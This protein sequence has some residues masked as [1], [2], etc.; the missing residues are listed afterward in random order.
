[1]TDLVLSSQQLTV[2]SALSSGATMTDAAE[3]A[4]V[5][6]NTIANWRRNF[7]PFEHALAH[8]Q[9]DRA[10]LFREKAEALADLAIQ[11]IQAIL[12][13]PKASAG[14]R[15]KAALAILQT[16]S[17]P[18]EPKKQIV[19]EI[20]KIKLADKPQ[21]EESN[22]HN[23]AQP[24]PQAPPQTVHNSAQQPRNVGPKIGRNDICPCGSG[25]KFK[26][27]CLNKPSSAPLA[28]AA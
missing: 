13:D 21:P 26:R 25:Q 3:E 18:P 28:A 14:V 2:I 9:Y 24:T 16:A 7:L 12:V 5:H 8:A 15:L 19:M 27:C 22:L 1:M 20:E 10:L 4:G 17:T 6:R 11:T 23:N